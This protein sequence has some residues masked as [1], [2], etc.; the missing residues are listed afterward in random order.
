MVIKFAFLALLNLTQRAR[1]NFLETPTLKNTF[2][3]LQKG[4]GQKLDFEDEKSIFE[5]CSKMTS[6]DVWG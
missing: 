1:M 6:K 3:S 5:K 4:Q 2:F